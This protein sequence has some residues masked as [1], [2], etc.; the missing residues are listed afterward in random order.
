MESQQV[1]PTRPQ[2]ESPPPLA[3]LPTESTPTKPA[4]SAP[5]PTTPF[6]AD[7]PPH[8]RN[9]PRETIPAAVRR[10]VWA[11]DAG[12][13]RWPLDGGGCCGST[14]RLELDHVIPW[15]DWGPSTIEN[16]RVVCGRHNALASLQA[17]DERCVARDAGRSSAG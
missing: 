16:L 5:P 14:H 4:P 8:R 9:G 6:T 11:R 1:A 12:R 2:Q 17:F 15:A 3:L 13:C 7:P 10:A